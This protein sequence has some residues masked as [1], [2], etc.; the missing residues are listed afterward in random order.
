[1]IILATN[2]QQDLDEAMHRRFVYNLIL[3]VIF[4]V[5]ITVCRIQVSVPFSL[6]DFALRM[7]IWKSHVPGSS[8]LADLS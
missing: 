6:P 7:E 5:V 3:S 2:R 4:K 1:M 8:P